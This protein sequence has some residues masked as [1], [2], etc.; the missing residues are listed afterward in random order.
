MNKAECEAA[1]IPWPLGECISGNGDFTPHPGE[2]RFDFPCSAIWRDFY[3]EAP[4]PDRVHEEK[5]A[6]DPGYQTLRAQCV[7]LQRRLNAIRPE[8]KRTKPSSR[9]T[10][11]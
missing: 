10:E 9:G 2:E 1:H 5:P 3:N 4:E 8:P 7:D 11:L 6:D